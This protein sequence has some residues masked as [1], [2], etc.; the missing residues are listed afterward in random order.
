MLV[1]SNEGNK[2]E[3]K[4]TNWGPRAFCVWKFVSTHKRCGSGQNNK[5]NK[6][7]KTTKKPKKTDCIMVQRRGMESNTFASFV[8][9]E[10]KK[11][12]RKRII[13]NGENL[14]IVLMIVS[15]QNK[16][17]NENGILEKESLFKH[18]VFHENSSSHSFSSRVK[19]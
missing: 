8:D 7:N 19:P 10:R 2:W 12:K 9:D 16:S 17:I 14:S 5:E 18:I 3:L 1:R 4:R 11:I 13:I 15:E 6:N